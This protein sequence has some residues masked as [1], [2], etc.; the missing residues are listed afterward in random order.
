VLPRYAQDSQRTE[1]ALRP[2][3]SRG[4]SGKAAITRFHINLFPFLVY[5]WT[6]PTIP[7]WEVT[8][9]PAWG[10]LQDDHSSRDM[11]FMEADDRPTEDTN[12]KY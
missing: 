11:K 12:G 2:A 1:S 7:L 8:H 9:P 4:T 5:E 3:I 10:A 6:Q